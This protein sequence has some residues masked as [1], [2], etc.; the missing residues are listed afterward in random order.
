MGVGHTG[1]GAVAACAAVLL[2][3]FQKQQATMKQASER[4]RAP[5]GDRPASKCH[6]AVIRRGGR[7]K[8]HTNCACLLDLK[9]VWVSVLCLCML[10]CFLLGCTCTW[11]GSREADLPIAIATRIPPLAAQGIRFTLH[12][13]HAITHTPH[14]Y[15]TT[16][17]STVSRRACAAG[18]S[19][20]A[21]GA[22]ALLM[23]RLEAASSQPAAAV[24]GHACRAAFSTQSSS[25]SFLS[26]SDLS[27]NPGAKTEV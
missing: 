18:S 11:P 26:L 9:G 3:A 14:L 23:R 25:T 27:D 10:V 2:K 15:S 22:A 8:T 21:C 19:R 24:A 13:M 6:C 1:C 20:L 17:L 4:A 7:K 5:L 12:I 16:M